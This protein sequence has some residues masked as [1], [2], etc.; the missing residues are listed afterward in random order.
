METAKNKVRVNI[1]GEE[2]FIRSEG[3]E[4]YIREVAGYLDRE[5]HEIAEKVPNKS[6]SRIAVL[7]ALNITDKLFTEKKAGGSKLSDF[8]QR[9]NAIISRLD[10]K[11]PEVSE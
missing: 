3:D 4:G 5:M 10:E 9:A 7:A 6:P 2:Y 8:E 11:L 1:Y